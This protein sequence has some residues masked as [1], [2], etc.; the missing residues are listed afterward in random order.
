MQKRTSECN[1][2][3]TCL[4]IK[5]LWSDTNLWLFTSDIGREE[6]EKVKVF[7]DRGEKQPD[8]GSDRVRFEVIERSTNKHTENE[9][10]QGALYNVSIW[11][12][13]VNEKL[14]LFHVQQSEAFNLVSA[15]RENQ[16]AAALMHAKSREEH[17]LC[18][19]I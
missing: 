13:I 14:D 11:W 10:K 12:L 2:K 9:V 18:L 17:R 1:E 19:F 8:G 16:S 7:T 4:N 15:S 3:T 6:S 5:P